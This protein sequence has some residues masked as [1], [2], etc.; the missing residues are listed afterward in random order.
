M[1]VRSQEIDYQKQIGTL[2]GRPVIEIGTKGG[3]HIV[4]SPRGR[5]VDYLGVGPHRRV[6]R[7]MAKK[8]APSLNITELEKS[9][10]IGPEHFQ[11][12]LPRYEAV[13]RGLIEEESKR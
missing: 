9:D 12:L 2:D 13:L 8:T 1:N 10:E 4:C 3:Y 6:A 11:H 5:K 7:F